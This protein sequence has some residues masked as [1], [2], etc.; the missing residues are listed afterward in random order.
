MSDQDSD[1]SGKDIS[2]LSWAVV[3]CVCAVVAVPSGLFSAVAVIFLFTEPNSVM[4]SEGSWMAGYACCFFWAATAIA[5][6]A[7]RTSAGLAP[8]NAGEDKDSHSG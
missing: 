7:F 6:F 1:T 4:K 3:G 8:R 5:Y 2:S